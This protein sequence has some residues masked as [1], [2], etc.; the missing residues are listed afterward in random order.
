MQAKHKGRSVRRSQGSASKRRQP[1][2]KQLILTLL[3]LFICAALFYI[4]LTEIDAPEPA[5]QN[6]SATLS[7]LVIDVGQADSILVTMSTGEV[8]LIDAGESDSVAAIHEELD[9]RNIDTIDILV[10]THPHADH[11]GGMQNIVENY[12]IGAIYMP[13]EASTSRVY[14]NLMDAVEARSI[15]VVEAYAG[16]QF[17]LGAAQCTIVSPGQEDDND[18]NNESVVIFL[19]YLDTECLF[20]GDMEESAEK[21]VL[22]DGYYIDADILKLGHHGSSTS[23]GE[24]FFDAVSPE[25]AVISCGKD[26][27]YGH[28][29]EETLNLL[30][31]NGIT[32]YRTDISG[33]ILFVSDGHTIQVTTGG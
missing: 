23:T 17:S 6:G 10:A 14:R 5:A 4:L 12:S 3:I 19:D 29:H 32:P 2:Q 9:E 22:A 30:T 26:N 20:T 33:D 18:A 13:D 15:P 21:E 31:E 24:E 8:M 1:T 7:V 27:S 25:Y 11:I 16:E 28:P